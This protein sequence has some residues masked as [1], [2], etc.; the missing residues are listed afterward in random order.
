[1]INKKFYINLAGKKVSATNNLFKF[2]P[3]ERNWFK[4]CKA[5]MFESDDFDDEESDFDEKERFSLKSKPNFSG[6]DQFAIENREKIMSGDDLIWIQLYKK[7]YPYV[8]SVVSNNLYGYKSKDEIE[9]IVLYSFNTL[10]QKLSDWKEGTGLTDWIAKIAKNRCATVRSMKS[11]YEKKFDKSYTVDGETDE[12]DPSSKTVQS[13]DKLKYK[14][15]SS[16]EKK[17][18]FEDIR[19]MLTE[20]PEEHSKALSLFVFNGLSLKEISEKTGWPLHKVKARL[21]D[22][23]KYARNWFFK[24]DEYGKLFKF[25]LD[26]SKE[27][28][29][30]MKAQ[31]RFRNLLTFRRLW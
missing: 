19:K 4:G 11:N 24:N 17:E 25:V 28:L 12:D 6:L 23:R 10:Y 20:L 21:E 13:V 1:M 29:R 18:F 14:P 9:D 15:D 16:L 22:A 7:F 3:E 31:S 27:S 30:L 8:Y 5:P 2:L 26:E